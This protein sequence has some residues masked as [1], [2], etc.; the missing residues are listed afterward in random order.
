M[1]DGRARGATGGGNFVT[2]FTPFISEREYNGGALSGEVR[3][4]TAR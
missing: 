2:Q 1:P 3:P 4:G